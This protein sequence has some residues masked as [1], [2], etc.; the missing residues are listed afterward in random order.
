MQFAQTKPGRNW[1]SSM[2]FCLSCILLTCFIFLAGCDTFLPPAVPTLTEKEA[3]QT[4]VSQEQTEKPPE[5]TPTVTPTPMPRVIVDI[6]AGYMVNVDPMDRILETKF[7]AID[8]WYGQDA[9]GAMIF[10]ITANC[11]GLCSRE[12]TFEMTIKALRANLGAMDGMLPPDIVEL[13]IITL[14]RFQP[15]GMVIVKWKDAFDYCNGKISDTQLAGRI[16]RP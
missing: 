15:S 1:Q 12:R 16:I 6:L 8:A 5:P 10:R 11:D 4:K 2:R 13:Q 9:N 3:K 7:E 14:N